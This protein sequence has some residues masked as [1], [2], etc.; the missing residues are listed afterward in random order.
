MRMSYLAH[1]LRDD[2]V[3]GG[4]LVPETLFTGAESPEIFGCLGDNIAAKLEYDAPE[5][6]TVGSHVEVN[7][8][9]QIS[10]NF[11]L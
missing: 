1:E 7:L 4:T 11:S 2:P 6:L 5:F 8:K 9:N 10:L 3:K